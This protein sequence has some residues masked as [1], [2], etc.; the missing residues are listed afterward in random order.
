MKLLNFC[1]PL[2][3]NIPLLLRWWCNLPVLLL[4]AKQFSLAAFRFEQALSLNQDNSVT[5]EAA[6]AHYLAADI[7]SSIERYK[8]YYRR[9]WSGN[10]L[11]LARMLADS[12]RTTESINAFS[13]VSNEASADDCLIMGNLFYQKNYLTS[14]TL[15]WRV[16]QPIQ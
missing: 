3:K 9:T 12:G 4:D 14:K 16:I 8:Q 10:Q 11:R 15:V 13:K 7:E 2:T 5:K 6:E 1:V